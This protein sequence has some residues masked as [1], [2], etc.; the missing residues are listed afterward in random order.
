MLN[1]VSD[2]SAQAQALSPKEP[3]RTT[4]LAYPP[5]SPSTPIPPSQRTASLPASHSHRQ[6]SVSVSPK[7]MPPPPPMFQQT[8]TSTPSPTMSRKRSLSSIS[9]HQQTPQPA[10]KKMRTPQPPSERNQTPQSAT[11]SSS[12]SSSTSQA[13]QPTMRPRRYST[14]PIWA[15][16]EADGHTHTQRRSDPPQQ[17]AAPSPVVQNGAPS[18][19]PSGPSLPSRRSNLEPSLDNHEPY[20]DTTRLV[21]NWLWDHVVAA[22][23]YGPETHIEIEAKLGELQTDKKRIRIPILTEAVM[24]PGR[25]TQ[26][27]SSMNWDQHKHLNKWLNNTFQQASTP[28]RAPMTYDHPQETDTLYDLPSQMLEHLHPQVKAAHLEGGKPLRVR[29][30]RDNKTN[31]VTAKIIKLRM[32]DLEIFCPNDTFDIRISVSLETNISK[33][34]WLHP[35]DD[36]QEHLD[37]GVAKPRSKDRVSFFHQGFRVDLTQVFSSATGNKTHELEIELK[38][39]DLKGEAEKIGRKLSNEYE[40]LV[41]VFLNNMRVVNRAARDIS[42]QQ[43]GN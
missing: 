39:D 25:G 30:T 35:V 20:S 2:A 5:Q 24:A 13:S 28:G 38:T 12:S 40:E 29:V 14:V 34:T 7:T 4:S 16:R 36:L 22:P 3:Q 9:D 6:T 23:D 33:T 32:A 11:T 31:E 8:S 43:N 37:K 17:P 18:L 42:S 41:R 10:P 15:L 27:E 1:P 21:A 19:Q 26:F